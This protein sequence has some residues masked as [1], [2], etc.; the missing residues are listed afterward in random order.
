MKLFISQKGI[1]QGHILGHILLMD[2]QYWDKT[3]MLTRH[4]S[5]LWWLDA[6]S[7]TQERSLTLPLS[8]LG[9]HTTS[10]RAH[11]EMNAEC[12]FCFLPFFHK[13]KNLGIP[14]WL[15]SLVPAFGPGH[16][17]GV[18]G[19]S[20]TS[21]SLRGACSSLCLCDLSLFLSQIIFF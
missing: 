14:G 18:P 4:S 17:P 21:G 10:V 9:M 15:S 8:L 13:S 3:Q 11:W 1:E 5:K 20:P 19:L 7:S 16:D 6:E 2:A 12:Y